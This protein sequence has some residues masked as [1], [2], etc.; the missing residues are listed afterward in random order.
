MKNQSLYDIMQAEDPKWLQ[1]IIESTDVAWLN[2]K[3]ARAVK[4][5]RKA[6]IK[7]RIENLTYLVV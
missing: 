5:G 3:E 1:T 2:K 6:I 7:A 4:P